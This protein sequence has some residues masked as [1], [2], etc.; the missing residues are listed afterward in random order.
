MIVSE[1]CESFIPLSCLDKKLRRK[2]IQEGGRE[3]TRAAGRGGGKKGGG[4]KE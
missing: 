3:I 1:H 2:G 4:G